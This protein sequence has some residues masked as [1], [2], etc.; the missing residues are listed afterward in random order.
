MNKK[1][2]CLYL[3][4]DCIDT[5]QAKS[6]ELGISY[7]DFITILIKKGVIVEFNKKP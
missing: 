6:K 5:L 4:E 2:I 1:R 7:S 3:T